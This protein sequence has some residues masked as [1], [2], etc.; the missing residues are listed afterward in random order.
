LSG[1]VLGFVLLATAV[2]ANGMPAI[3]LTYAACLLPGTLY[4]W[5]AP[6]ERYLRWWEPIAALNVAIHIAFNTLA[7]CLFT[8]PDSV[9]T[10]AFIAMAGTLIPLGTGFASCLRA[11]AVAG[12]T[13]LSIAAGTTTILYQPLFASAWLGVVL[14]WLLGGALAVIASSQLE[15]ALR[16]EFVTGQQLDEERRRADA[17]LRN[18]LPAEIAERLKHKPGAIA[19][20]FPE[21]T[22]LFADLVG[23]TPLAQRLPPEQVVAL[24]NELFSAFDD[25]AERHGLEKIKTIGDAYMVVGGAPSPR[26]DHAH[27]VAA[28]ALEMRELVAQH[29]AHGTELKL[30]IGIDCGPVVAGVI[31]KRKLL[32]DLWGDTVNTASRMESHGLE[33]RVQVTAAVFERLRDAFEFEAR[34]PIQVKGKGEMPT[35][36]LKAAAATSTS[37]APAPPATA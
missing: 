4:L 2:F 26:P 1:V 31:G 8:V 22:V 27:A 13:I 36:W 20:R 34:G 37:A 14:I 23:F 21:A 25:L 33:D 32:Y 15:R 17:L 30:R 11:R 7:W 28:M 18:M 29:R 16:Q 5:L 10:I 3:Q 12:A 9:V 24:L 19:E 6:E 35:W